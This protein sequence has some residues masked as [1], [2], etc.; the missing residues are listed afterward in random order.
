MC[1]VTGRSFP[2]NAQR[3]SSP[4]VRTRI[5]PFRLVMI[6]LISELNSQRTCLQM[7]QGT[8]GPSESQ[9]TA[10]AANSVSPSDTALPTAH[11]SA[12]VPAG[13][14]ADSTLQPVYTLPDFPQCAARSWRREYGA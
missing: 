4:A 13:N 9:T 1:H 7:P 3:K 2:V 5:S 8:H 10:I 14:D 11:L 6:T 12:H